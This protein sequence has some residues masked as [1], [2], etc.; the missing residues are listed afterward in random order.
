MHCSEIVLVYFQ[1]FAPIVPKSCNSLIYVSHILFYFIFF[2]CAS[3]TH[4]IALTYNLFIYFNTNWG[5]KLWFLLSGSGSKKSWTRQA[6]HAEHRFVLK[7]KS[8]RWII[9]RNDKMI[10]FICVRVYTISNK[11]PVFSDIFHKTKDKRRPTHT[12]MN[13]HGWI[14]LVNWFKKGSC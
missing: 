10:C 12:V 3:A 4:Y 5:P 6:L 13:Q 9:I 11:V 14:Y 2:T 7:S 8:F 1:F